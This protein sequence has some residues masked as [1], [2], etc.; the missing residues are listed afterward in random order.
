MTRIGFASPHAVKASCPHARL[1]VKAVI[2]VRPPARLW[3][4]HTVID[5]VSSV[6]AAEGST[7]AKRTRSRVAPKLTVLLTSSGRRAQAAGFESQET[8]AAQPLSA[9]RRRISDMEGGFCDGNNGRDRLGRE[10]Q[11]LANRAAPPGVVVG[12]RQHPTG[13]QQPPRFRHE[14]RDGALRA[15]HITPGTV[16]RRP[17]GAAIIIRCRTA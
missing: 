5:A 12:D 14:R 10:I 3:G 8:C 16:S 1:H 13:P 2:L 6:R 4:T 11:R 7:R 9:R 15:L 17:P